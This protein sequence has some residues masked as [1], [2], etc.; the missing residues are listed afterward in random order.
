MNTIKYLNQDV[1]Y[2]ILT[3]LNSIELS[4][5]SNEFE[6]YVNYN[7]TDPYADPF[8]SV[9]LCPIKLLS[10]KYPKS[11]SH[12]FRIES[13]IQLAYSLLDIIDFNDDIEG[14]CTNY[15]KNNEYPNF[16]VIIEILYYIQL[17]QKYPE[18]H[19]LLPH[20]RPYF[21]KNR[22]IYGVIYKL[23][24]KTKS[25]VYELI[26]CDGKV[27]VDVKKLLL[28]LHNNRDFTSISY[29]CLA[30]IIIKYH[31]IID[32]G[33][34]LHNY[35]S[36]QIDNDPLAGIHDLDLPENFGHL[37]NTYVLKQ[38]YEDYVDNGPI[39]H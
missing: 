28:E 26:L 5:V 12:L 30:M 16:N 32:K 33:T 31:L 38:L 13:D 18:V 34:L 37:Y 1:F 36:F 9:G 35:L 10:L 24:D 6:L 27:T 19:K 8:G 29:I 4:K 22:S 2:I 21:Y 7:G 11:A 20:L 39:D 23:C 25:Y 3:Y 17:Q 14:T 15:V